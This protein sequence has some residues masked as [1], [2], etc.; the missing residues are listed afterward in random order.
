ME[1]YLGITWDFC[2]K[3]R[4]DFFTG[5]MTLKKNSD[6]YNIFKKLLPSALRV[7]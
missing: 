2:I 5:E 3:H 4:V 7:E 6:I 1:F